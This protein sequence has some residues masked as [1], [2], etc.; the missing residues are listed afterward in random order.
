MYFGE[1]FTH[2]VGAGKEMKDGLEARADLEVLKI[3]R[4]LHL[5][6]QGDRTYLTPYIFFYDK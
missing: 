2:V 4:A 3:R 5:I 6:Q 1:I